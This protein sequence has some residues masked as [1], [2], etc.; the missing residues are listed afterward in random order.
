MT[1]TEKT[2]TALDRC[3]ACG[4]QAWVKAT[5]SSG[6]LYFC[7]H[8]ARAFADKLE[9]AATEILDETSRLQVE[10]QKHAPLTAMQ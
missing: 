2:F 5:L 7:A 1:E 10:E 9:G 6:E 4:A 3:D 8:H